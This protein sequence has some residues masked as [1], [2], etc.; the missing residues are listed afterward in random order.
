MAAMIL[1]VGLPAFALLYQKPSCTDRRQNQGELDI[2]CGGPCVLLCR[3]SEKELVV[4]WQQ[5]FKVIDGVYTAVAY[6]QNPNL[7]AEAQRV[8]YTFMIYDADNNLITEKKGTTYIPP[9]KKFVI[10]E[11]GINV[12][13]RVA[14][15]T[16]VELDKNITWVRAPLQRTEPVITKQALTNASTSPVIDADIQ[17]S[18]FL[19]VPR[20]FVYA[21]VYDNEGNAFAASRT[22]VDGLYRQTSQHIVFTWPQPFARNVSRFDLIVVPR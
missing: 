17:N 1:F 16:F 4:E 11:T 21:L 13:D 2:D 22:I 12:G 18:T 9:G 15:R 10:M 7:N 8:A 3:N 6:I 20:V 5:S 14:V 19:D